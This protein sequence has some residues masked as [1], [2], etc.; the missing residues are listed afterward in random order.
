MWRWLE[1]IWIA[2]PVIFVCYIALIFIADAK[3]ISDILITVFIILLLIIGLGLDDFK[4][5]RIFSNKS[6]KDRSNVT[7]DELI[8]RINE[9]LENKKILEE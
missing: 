5:F 7:N 2:I 8:E 9:N 6:K 3:S 1:K 4:H